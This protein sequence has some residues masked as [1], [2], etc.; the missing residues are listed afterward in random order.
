M[1]TKE[2]AEKIR[3]HDARKVH[4]RKTISG[5]AER[6]R[7]TVFKSN[8]YLYVQAIDDEAGVTLAA[9]STLEEALKGNRP[10]VA[11]GSK[12]GELIGSRLGEKKI[13]TVVF[14]RNGYNYHGI[15]KAIADGTRKTG[16]KF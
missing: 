8:K 15:V 7:L 11:T 9:A 16:I 12:L 5:T 14:D 1:S 13:S 3:R 10:T 4:V 6:P 2:L